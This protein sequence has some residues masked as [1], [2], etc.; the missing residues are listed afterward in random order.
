M[1]PLHMQYLLSAPKLPALVPQKLMAL[2]FLF[3]FQENK[4]KKQ[5][6]RPK[7]SNIEEYRRNIEEIKEYRRTQTNIEETGSSWSLWMEKL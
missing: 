6:T 1:T 5:E 7:E 2:P 4:A 3:L